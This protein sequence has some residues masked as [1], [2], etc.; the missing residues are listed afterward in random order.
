MERDLFEHY[1]EL[2]QEV[3]DVLEKYAEEDNTY[4]VNEKLLAELKPLG[5]TFEYGLDAVPFNLQ[6]I[7]QTNLKT[8]KIM[9]TFKFS[10]KTLLSALTIVSKAFPSKVSCRV[11]ILEYF[12]FSVTGT[13]LTISVTDLSIFYSVSMQVES[14]ANAMFTAVVPQDLFKYLGKIKDQ[15]TADF[16]WVPSSY[17]VEVINDGERAKFSGENPEAFPKRVETGIYEFSA[18]GIMFSQIKRLLPYMSDDA[19]RTN[20]NCIGFVP[21]KGSMSMAATNGHAL[22]VEHLEGVSHNIGFLLNP[23]AAKLV[24]GLK[25]DKDAIVGVYSNKERTSTRM[26]FNAGDFETEITSRNHDERFPN[27]PDVFP[28]R[29]NI[30]TWFDVGKAELLKA[31]DKALLFSNPSTNMVVLSSV[32]GDI[33]IKAENLDESKEVSIKLKTSSARGQ[34]LEIGFNG[35]LLATV[36]ES[37]GDA[38]TL[39][40]IAPNKAASIWTGESQ[41]L[42]MPIMIVK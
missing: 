33:T 28:D 41:T 11:P 7:T 1:E 32:D 22:R 23:A 17:S 3:N 40:L 9:N 31:I 18:K 13:R 26:V 15:E 10:P 6:K 2:P 14:L 16:V 42:L 12:L 36:I 24:S 29:D 8:D 21:Q 34:D 19:I 35:K 25:V 27:Y 38:F 20:I 37:H 5:Y 39:E 30:K 4:E